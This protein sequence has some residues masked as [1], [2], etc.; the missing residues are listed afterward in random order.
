MEQHGRSG[1]V[2]KAS[3]IPAYHQIFTDLNDRILA[4]EWPPDDKLPTE[5]EL[6]EHYS[7]SRVTV[8]QALGALEQVG[9]IKKVKGSGSIVQKREESIIHD[10][11]LPSTLCAKL[12]QRGINLDADILELRICPP[13]ARINALLKLGAEEE[14]VHIRRIFLHSARPIALNDSWIHAELVPGIVENGL[15]DG[16]L[17]TTL[18]QRYDLIPSRIENILE[19]VRPSTSE[20]SLLDIPFDTPL[21][22]V[23]STSYLPYSVPLE[24][25]RTLWLAD[26]VKFHFDMD[27]RDT[28]I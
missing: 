27:N 9:L 3:P 15:I 28:K 19:A 4:N 24:Y 25:S 14:L 13:I 20:I 1:R 11:S 22:A 21:I 7:A 23:T 26:R 16:H 8:R 17:S 2:D 5:K 12:G 18:A 10:F 6:G